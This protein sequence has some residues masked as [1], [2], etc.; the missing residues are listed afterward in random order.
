[1]VE[2]NGL[3]GCCDSIIVTDPDGVTTNVY[4]AEYSDLLVAPTT[5]TYTLLFV[6]HPGAFGTGTFTIAPVAPDVTGTAS[7]DGGVTSLTTTTPNQNMSLTFTAT[8][9]QRLSLLVN[10]SS[11]LGGCCD[12]ITVTDPDGATQIV[13]TT[14]F[15]GTFFSDLLVA[16]TTGTYTIF[17]N[18]VGISFGTATFQL[19][20]VAP[21]LTATASIDGGAT[22]L[23]TTTPAQNMSVT[24]TATAGQRFSLLTTESNGLGGCCDDITITEPDGATQLVATTDFFGTFFSDLL[25][26]PTTGTYT[27]LLNPVRTAFGTGTFQ[28]ASVAPDATGTAAIDGGTTTLTTTTPAQNMSVTF[29]ATAGQRFSL[30]ATESNG[31][32]GCCDDITITESDGTTQLVATTDFFGTFFS[33]LLVAPTTGTYTILLNPVSTRF[34]SAT[35]H[36][37]SVAPD[38]TGTLTVGGPATSITTTTPAQNIVLTFTGT[39]GQG[40][41]LQTNDNIALDDDLIITE[42]DGVTQLYSASLFT[43]LY[44]PSTS[45]VLVT[46]TS[47]TYT[48]SLNANSTA[49]GTATFQLFSA[50]EPNAT[51]TAGS[52]VSLT[53]TS[54]GQPMSVTVAGTAGQTVSLLVQQDSTL[55]TGCNTLSIYAPDGHTLIYT[56]NSCDVSSFFTGAGTLPTTG[57][58]TILLTPGSTTTGT[59]TFT[60][61]DVPANVFANTTIGA[62]AADYTTTVPGQGIQVAFPGTASQTVTVSIGVVS[63]TPSGQCFQITTLEADGVTA[64]QGDYSCS[65]AY[66]SGS[67][68][69]PV[70]GYYGVLVQ[71]SS[72]TIGTYSVHITSP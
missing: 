15:F 21:D 4:G 43:G 58:Y 28:L 50:A 23:T 3:G 17:L 19:A 11:G 18:P 63:S 33:D 53:A 24:F 27:I 34:G 6:P 20:S 37:A 48:I 14:D 62:A 54:G 47:G 61:Y 40:I 29:T 22:S 52:S 49:T 65:S 9:G 45:G 60:L 68:T 41:I 25:V 69:L 13:A 46:P 59:A 32:G 56:L 64:V 72:T 70:S 36:L 57:T 51:I 8:A 71:P 12:D 38:A 31:L 66:S 16:P 55:A 39:A 7:I 1:L 26:A 2:S 30:L 5:G 67:I 35:F 42:P 10:E 44:G